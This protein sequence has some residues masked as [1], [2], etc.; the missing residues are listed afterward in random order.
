MDI[1]IITERYIET[2]LEKHW[3]EIFPNFKLISFQF[4]IYGCYS[5]RK[6]GIADVAFKKGKTYFIGELKWSGQDSED[7]WGSFKA[8]GYAKM[9]GLQI[10][11]PVRPVAIFRKELMSNDM[12]TLFYKIKLDYMLISRDNEGFLVEY[13]FR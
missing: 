1:N 3:K 4:P 5:Q 13:D 9:F 2:Y 7:V 12:R 8:I 10:K 6:I 11:Q